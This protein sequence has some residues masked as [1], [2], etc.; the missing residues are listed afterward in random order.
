MQDPEVQESVAPSGGGEAAVLRSGASPAPSVEASASP[1]PAR[2]L[3]VED[4]ST[5]PVSALPETG[6]PSLLALGAGIGAA[7]LLAVFA[8]GFPAV[9]SVLLRDGFG[10]R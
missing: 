5:E 9:R 2:R 8:V 3:S 4:A 6:G 10:G 7:G 1:G